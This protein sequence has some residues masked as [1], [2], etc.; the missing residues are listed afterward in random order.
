[1]AHDDK[2]LAPSDH[3]GSSAV[4]RAHDTSVKSPQPGMGVG[5]SGSAAQGGGRPNSGANPAKSPSPDE[6]NGG[7]DQAE[8]RSGEPRQ[9]SSK[10]VTAK[11]VSGEG[12]SPRAPKGPGS[13]PNQVRAIRI[14][15][16]MSK[17]ELARR[18][19]LSVLTVDRV[20]KGYGC[21]MDTKRK[22]LEALGLSLN[23][24]VRVF[25]EQV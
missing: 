11:Q 3:S 5:G 18:A 24:R 2:Y 6:Q 22:I 10:D 16:M 21:R 17:A 15:R 12:Q 25:G 14:E 1:M 4:A 13:H 8:P 7:G 9:S 23:D 19:N 20:E